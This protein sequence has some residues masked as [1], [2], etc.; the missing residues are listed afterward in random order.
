MNITISEFMIAAAIGFTV[1]G[2]IRWIMDKRREMS[3]S[4]F[5]AFELDAEKI[6]E[7]VRVT[8]GSDVAALMRLHNGGKPMVITS[9]KKSSV[10]A[11]SAPDKA[12]SMRTDWQ[13]VA[14][15]GDDFDTLVALQGSRGKS[16]ILFAD[17]L[18]DGVMRM[19]FDEHGLAGALLAEVF[20]TDMG[21]YYVVVEVRENLHECATNGD[22]YAL[23][24]AQTQLNRLCTD[25]YNRG[26]LE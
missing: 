11:E 21:Y 3:L 6:L 23:T 8:A 18:R 5:R 14:V 1:G 25:A 19:R 13:G 17:K 2:I 7:R 20:A 22:M 26:I 10:I 12:A 9:L 15:F 24:I 4:S 16:S